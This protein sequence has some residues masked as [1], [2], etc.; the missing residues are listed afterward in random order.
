MEQF[1][2]SERRI[3]RV[4]SQPRFTQRYL[5]RARDDEGLLTYRMIE[6]AKK[7]GRYGYRRIAALF[8]REWLKVPQKQPKRKR[9]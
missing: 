8:Q 7:C 2:V 9:L 3:C 4:L 5:C 1:D 6:L